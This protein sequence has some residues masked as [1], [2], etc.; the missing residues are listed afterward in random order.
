[1]QPADP[2]QLLFIFSLSL[3]AYWLL[4]LGLF[5]CMFAVTLGKPQVAFRA[6]LWG[7]LVMTIT[8]AMLCSLSFTL[9]AFAFVLAALAFAAISWEETNQVLWSAD[10]SF[11][12]VL[13]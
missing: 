9:A 2:G 13:S 1:L 10:Y 7:C 12:A 4:G 6:V 5:N 8:G 11:A 3:V